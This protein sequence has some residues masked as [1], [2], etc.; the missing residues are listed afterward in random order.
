MVDLLLFVA[1]LGGVLFGAE[2]L[3]RGGARLGVGLG[4][5][6]VIIGLTVVAFGTSAPELAVSAA[7]A[8]EKN[9]EMALGNA[10]GSNVAN[11]GLVLGLAA[12]VRPLACGRDVAR[13]DAP[14]MLLLSVGF[15]GL[16][17]TGSYER[18]MGAL[19]LATLAG[20]VGF[21]FYRARKGRS[22]PIAA[23]DTERPH[24]A[25]RRYHATQSALIVGGL[26]MLVAGAAILVV[27]AE[28]IAET[29]G[30]P[31]AVIAT[32]LVAFGTSVP[33][34]ATTAVAAFRRQAAIAVGG[35]IGS[36]IFNFLAVIGVAATIGPMPIDPATR[37][38][39]FLWVI[40][41]AAVTVW[42]VWQWRAITRPGGLALVVAYV[43]FAGILFA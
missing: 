4:V 3:V 35:V 15:L 27:G 1:G 8:L 25:G 36:N 14:L 17:W 19:M 40:G 41:F 9:P 20:Y 38:N 42:L 33:E 11:L 22:V 6:P 30:V 2:W 16:A 7:A 12:V 39:E 26:A 43:A 10:L 32:T 31:D 34:M 13:Y 18:W 37:D 29:L 23:H 28:G 24:H 5:P 21:S